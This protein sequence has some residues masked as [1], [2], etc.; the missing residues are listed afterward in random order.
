MSRK[1]QLTKQ[2]DDEHLRGP[3]EP[4]RLILRA[5]SSI[6][7]AIVLLAFI[8]LY[9]VLASV[10]IGLLA[11]IPTYLIIALTYLGALAVGALLPVIILRRA[12]RRLGRATRFTLSLLAF[13]ALGV[14]AS[15]LWLRLA[16]P[17]LR[18]D[19]IT[20]A[21]LRLFPEFVSAYE[22]KTVRR[23]PFLEMTEL[24]FYSWWPLFLVLMLFVMNMV[25]ATIRR[26]EFN[27][28]NLG[29]L[30]VHTGI[31]LIAL[32]SLF[33]GR[34]KQEGDT[35]L[36]AAQS[37]GAPG[38]PQV[39]FY[40]R[41][42][43][44][45]YVAQTLAQGGAPRPGSVP[46][47]P[48]WEQRL[49]RDL[50]RYNDY[51]L[52]AGVDGGQRSLW[53]VTGADRAWKD[54]P[55][56]PLSLRVPD[57][58]SGLVDPDIS[59]RVVGYASYAEAGEDLVEQPLD[60]GQPIPSGFTPSPLRFIELYSRLEQ[61]LPEGHSEDDGHNHAP[62]DP[63]KPVFRYT[64]S[65]NTPARRISDNGAF[66]VEYTEGMDEARWSALSAPI[67]PG[68]QHALIVEIPREGGVYRNAMPIVPGVKRT[69][70]D[71]GFSLRVK[72]ILP[73]PPFPIITPGYEGA[74]C[75]VAIVEIEAPAIGDQP[76]QT[77]DRWVY[78]RFP[79]I[80]QDLLPD[81]DPQSGRP[82]RRDADPAIRLTL[83]DASRLQ[84]YIDARP[85]GSA[86]AIVRQPGG[87]VRVVENIEPGAKLEDIVPKIDLRL[88]ERWDHARP[89]ERPV[90]VPV[91]DRRAD[92]IGTHDEALVAVEVSLPSGWSRVVWLPFTR[93]MHIRGLDT[94]RDVDLPDGRR[95][96]LAFGRLQRPLP[97]F[98]LRLVDFEMIA[99]DHR[100][101]PRDY[102]SIVRVEP[103]SN[104]ADFEPYEHV[105]KLNNPLRAPYHWSDDR[106]W[107]AN[108]ALRLASGLNPRQFKL[109]QSGWDR[110][111]WTETQKLVDAGQLDRPRAS[112]TILGVGNNPG[113][114]II[115][116]G[117]VLMA[118][119][120]PW[121]FYVKPWLV[122]REKARLKAQHA[123]AAKTRAPAEPEPTENA[124]ASEPVG[125]EA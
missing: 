68:T 97:D 120:I 8:A 13:I 96:R 88:A 53:S 101:A 56:L 72:E 76:A 37:P 46:G 2:W 105:T 112:F 62:P 31:V 38:P 11:L 29:V 4:L 18:Y 60:P 47:H 75:A 100:G 26:I 24:Q 94:E 81:V 32:G 43:V 115:A 86:R 71:T 98:R 44:V 90:P 45:L 23:L 12:T 30:T 111:G 125:A 19:P 84:V 27:F 102:Q 67:P 114:H 103:N 78:H 3:L 48:A 42:Q 41:E 49:L 118:L 73:E 116:L 7:M 10:P 14:L 108:T 40:D 39:A 95:V 79:E 109:S 83:I 52:L 74:T 124:K 34:F 93:Y 35:I 85:D 89:F 123:S 91:K 28:K 51:N 122:R 16:W 15:V 21:G 50:P 17:V 117:G 36:F 63:S 69:L 57:G 22:A 9:A 66:A 80:A 87:S 6:T 92:R 54:N 121:A 107:F 5:F 64:L 110:A 77:Y 25:V 65:P 20:G 59:F 113:I 119:G 99:Y 33:Y 70:S 82:T 104:D 58:V 61:P 106:S 55:G 1:W